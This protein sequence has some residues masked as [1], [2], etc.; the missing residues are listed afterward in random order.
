MISGLDIMKHKQKQEDF[1]KG[2]DN[3]HYSGNYK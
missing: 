1:E 3:G 2:P